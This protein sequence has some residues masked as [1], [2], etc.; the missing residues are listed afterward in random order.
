LS[1]RYY[2]T[3]QFAERASVTR[4]TLRFYDRAGLLR[5]Q[6]FTDS[7]YRLY[8]DE[9]L[10]RLQQI[11]ALKFLGFPLQDI[12]I[13]LDTGPSG[14]A[15]VL[16][17]QKAMLQARQE[18][19]R[20]VLQAVEKTEEL[21]RVGECGWETIA[22]VIRTIQMEQGTDKVRAHLTDEQR[23]RLESAY[24]Q[25]YSPEARA[26][27]AEKLAE[28]SAPQGSEADQVRREWVALAVEAQRLANAGADPAGAEGQ[29]LARRRSEL[30]SA[31]AQGDPQIEQGVQ[32]FA[33]QLRSLPAE[34]WPVP[35]VPRPDV[36]AEGTAFMQKALEA[37]RSAGE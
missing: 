8:S 22:E 9:D 16:A 27:L 32:R 14:L 11:L 28:G 21:L 26:K 15:E 19:L 18:Q 7:G 23:W 12:K 37:Y 35:G 20:M 30:M 4:R 6:Q 1:A 36:S 3:G 24:E 29:S 5:P 25:A 17:Q 2:R 34:K 13:C 10:L 31:F 33:E